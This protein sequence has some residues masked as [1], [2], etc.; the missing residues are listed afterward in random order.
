VHARVG[1]SLSQEDLIS[2]LMQRDAGMM[3]GLQ[4]D[5]LTHLGR[6]DRERPS[7]VI[8]VSLVHSRPM[9]RRAPEALTIR[10][11]KARTTE[12]MPLVKRIPMALEIDCR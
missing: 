3:T 7:R 5:A 4:S 12:A 6:A 2:R 11:L 8:G 9:R 1:A 10:R